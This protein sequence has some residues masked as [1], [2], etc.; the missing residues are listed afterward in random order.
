MAKTGICAAIGM[1]SLM[2]II[3]ASEFL[4][5]K[6]AAFDLSMTILRNR[7][8]LGTLKKY[9]AAIGHSLPFRLC[10]DGKLK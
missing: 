7:V 10:V 2:V 1:L 5:R 6:P 8:G 9:S 4:A 3:T